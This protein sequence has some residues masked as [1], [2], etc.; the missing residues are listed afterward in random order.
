M[1]FVHLP[2]LRFLCFQKKLLHCA[3]VIKRGQC[4]YFN[5]LVLSTD[6]NLSLL[7]PSAA[8]KKLV[9]FPFCSSVTRLAS[10]TLIHLYQSGQWKN[11][12]S[13]LPNCIASHFKLRILIVSLSCCEQRVI[14]Y[15]IQFKTARN[16]GNVTS[17]YSQIKSLVNAECYILNKPFAVKKKTWDHCSMSKNFHNETYEFNF[18]YP[19]DCCHSANAIHDI[20]QHLCRVSCL[21]GFVLSFLKSRNENT[22]D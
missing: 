22:I 1:V 15:Q 19:M 3:T 10:Y 14:W 7:L 6:Y 17:F 11:S 12:N 21:F 8:S 5:N 16:L 4:C 9:Y 13:D 18:H 2:C 20:K